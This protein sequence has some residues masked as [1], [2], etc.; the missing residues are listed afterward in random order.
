MSTPKRTTFTLLASVLFVSCVCQGA[1]AQPH[2]LFNGID[3]TGWHTDVPAADNDPDIRPSFIVRDGLVV[4]MGKPGGHLISDA[5][6]ENY[7]LDVEYRFVNDAGNCGVLVNASTP[8][9]LHAMF[10]ASIEVQMHRDNAGDFWCI[11]ENIAVNNMADHRAGASDNWGRG[12][13]HSTHH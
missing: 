6:Y 1:L 9:A 12:P 8:R 13:K 3:L 11:A 5:I 2:S 10:P 4:S 7:R